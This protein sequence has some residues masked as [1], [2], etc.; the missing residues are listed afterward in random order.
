MYVKSMLTALPNT[1][2]KVNVLLPKRYVPHMCS[3]IPIAKE[4]EW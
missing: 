3:F 4:M 2:N 1:L